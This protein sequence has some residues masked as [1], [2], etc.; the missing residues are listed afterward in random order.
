GVVNL[1][2]LRESPGFGRLKDLVE[3]RRRMGV[4]II[5]HQHNLLRFGI[6][7]L[8]EFADKVCPIRF[9]P[10]FTHLEKAFTAQRFTGQKEAA[11]ALPLVLIV[12]ALWLSRLHWKWLAGLSQQ[13][14]TPFIQ[15]NLRKA[16]IIG[17]RIHL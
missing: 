14:F 1:Q 11:G 13:L 5:E 7:N 9:R 8:D 16:C 3:R 17:S 10:L 12:K 6:V 4:E 2:L 15:A